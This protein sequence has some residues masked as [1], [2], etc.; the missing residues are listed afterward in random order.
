L[1][2]GD[3]GKSDTGIRAGR[4]FLNKKKYM[5]SLQLNP[6]S[7][8]PVIIS[9]DRGMVRIGIGWSQQNGAFVDLTKHEVEVLIIA[10]GAKAGLDYMLRADSILAMK[11]I[12]D[13]GELKEV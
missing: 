13:N 9:A 3:R 7:A 8:G 4:K 6:A 1:R 11:F 12:I 2:N 10:L 5:K